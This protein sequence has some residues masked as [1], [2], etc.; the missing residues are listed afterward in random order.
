MMARNE[1]SY[2][3]S[4]YFCGVKIQV[5][6]EV[7]AWSSVFRALYLVEKSIPACA[8]AVMPAKVSHLNTLTA[9]TGIFYVKNL[10]V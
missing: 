8:V 2:A 4:L 7:A 10:S 1:L 6:H 5:R 9:R 3:K